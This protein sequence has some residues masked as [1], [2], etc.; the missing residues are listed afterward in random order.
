M[1][2]RAAQLP[3]AAAIA[4]VH[5]ESWRTTYRGLVPDDV[6]ATLSVEQ[7]QRMWERTFTEFAATNYVYVAEAEG[8]GVVG[9]ISGGREREGDAEYAGELYAI[10]LLASHQRRGLG[11]QLTRALVERLLQESITSMLVWVLADNPARRFYESLGGQYLR[12][13][14]FTLG[15]TSLIEVAYGWRDIRPLLG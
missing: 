9:F 13:K 15:E 4:R 10:Y 8:D 5:V 2:I 3:D 7:R 11:H 14:P 12:E 1:L 6:L